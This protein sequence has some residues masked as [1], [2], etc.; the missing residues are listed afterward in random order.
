[1]KKLTF[2][3]KDFLKIGEQPLSGTFFVNWIKILIENKFN[4]DWRYLPKALYVTIMIL[5]MT[6]FR[7]FE[8]NSFDKIKNDIKVKSPI[9]IIGHWRSGTTFLHY[10]MGQDKNLAY[11]STFETMTPNMMIKKEELF[12]NIVKN[13]LPNKRPMDNLELHADLPY[14]EE[15]AVA[16]LSP[17][18]FYHAWYFPKKMRK[19][20]DQNVLYKNISNGIKEKWIETY[21]YFLKKITYKNNGNQI[22]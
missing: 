14:E 2:D 22:V 5:I 11:V 9:F 16:N 15:Y 19:Y 13:H 17:Y 8:K 21:D 3:K 1:M 6:P 7:I 4:I 20:F 18:S 12:K 10:L